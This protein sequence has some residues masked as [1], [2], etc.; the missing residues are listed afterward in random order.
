MIAL[1]EEV[2]LNILGTEAKIESG[3]ST[4]KRPRHTNITRKDQQ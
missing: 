4:R 2:A 1:V 3:T